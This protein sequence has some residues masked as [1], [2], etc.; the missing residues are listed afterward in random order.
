MTILV[1]EPQN[2]EGVTA[3]TPELS[4]GEKFSAAWK[5]Q[6]VRPDV[7]S[8]S[9]RVKLGYKREIFDSLPSEAKQRLAAGEQPFAID[10]DAADSALFEEAQ[11][12]RKE[13]P[14]D[15]INLPTSADE[16]EEKTLKRRQDE[17]KEAQDLLAIDGGG[18]AGFVGG[19]A[20]AMTDPLSLAMLPLGLGSGSLMRLTLSEAVLGG[21]SEAL[22][23][24][25]EYRVAGEL[26]IEDPNPVARI[27]LGAG[28]GGGFAL[29]IGGA[30]RMLSYGALRR[31]GAKQAGRAGQA[32][33]VDAVNQAYERLS[34]LQDLDADVP[35]SPA[36][37]WARPAPPNW[38]AI[39]NGI[40]VGESGGDYNALFG[41]Q[42]RT[43]GRYANVKLTEMTV[44]D[45][46]AFSNVNGDY[47]QWV[48][49]QIGRV[50]TPMGAYQI[51][52]TT[53][54]AAKKGLGLTGKEVMSEDLQ[55]QLGMWIYRRQGTGAWEGYRGPRS[56]P[57]R[58]AS[59]DAP[60]PEFT[61]YTSRGYTGTGQV[62]V[63][64]N[65]RIDVE[66]QVVDLSSLRQ[67]AG[68]LQPRDRARA[69]SDAWVADTAARLD[70]ALL[71]PSPTA[72]R[73]API[74]GPDNMIESGNGRARAIGRAYAEN[75]DR[76]A[77]Y[78]Q[79]IELTTGQ[80]IPEGITEPVLIARRQTA[81]SSGDRRQMVVEAQDSGVARMN[82]TERAQV[83]QRALTA[84]L[85]SRYVPGRKFSSA[86]NRD[87]ARAFS[88]SFPRSERNAFFDKDGALSIDGVRQLNDAV[89][90]RAYEA[91]DILARYV[92][93]EP[94][95]LRSL[96][97][98]LSEAAPDIALLRAEIEAGNVRPE[99][100]ITPFVLDAARLIMSARDLAAREGSTAAKVVEEMLDDIDLLDGA[101]AP[102]TQALVRHLVPG[103][104]Q[105]PAAKISAFLKRYVDE[106]RKAGRTGD[107]L[108]EQP[109]PLDVLKAIDSRAFGDLVET[110]A[111]RMAN[112]VP[113]QVDAEVIPAEAFAK[114][115]A[116]PE[117]QAADALAFD[118]LV[119]AQR[120]AIRANA[121]ALAD[122]A[123]DLEFKVEGGEVI[124]LRDF[125]EDLDA[126]E[127]AQAV[128]D[129]CT[130]G[131]AR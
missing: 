26:G 48:K 28:L 45:A 70:P 119:E 17:L 115:A 76:A 40:F 53:L 33:D 65:L 37:P 101:V 30:A 103:G 97:E 98:A 8:Y 114:G 61:G 2:P 9:S 34:T 99:M 52:G 6:T 102:L 123:D 38:E 64:D 1:E 88:G 46:I 92:E 43:G 94:G 51:V 20:R 39:K 58:M 79:Q 60:A 105:A 118:Q 120:A 3:A 116:S 16:L 121:S 128:I 55:D 109:G 75:P 104:K 19:S 125:M 12:A 23:L 87:F 78:R 15:W 36:A 41:Y 14:N 112:P 73:G 117:A 130:L 91:P 93:T 35:A 77:A 31:E 71:M 44:D 107:A 85:M 62:A 126:D 21:A 111:A 47:G 42:N 100:D 4:F 131:G 129:A 81:L 66:Y 83:G 95:E 90:A 69:A 106:A 84:D 82:A 127:T 18:F 50:A 22:L 96:L 74:V 56:Q 24:P 29:G 13:T 25:R 27:A 68:D 49:G 89:F 5:E 122:V 63:G 86:E 72:D 11:K 59:G 80:P 110:G 32:T 67:A 54:K 7:W 108:F 57:P 113:A 10:T 124:S